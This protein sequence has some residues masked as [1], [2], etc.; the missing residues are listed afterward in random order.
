MC[1]SIKTQIPGFEGFGFLTALL[2]HENKRFEIGVKRL[3]ARLSPGVPPHPHHSVYRERGP[4]SL[5]F[6]ALE[7]PLC[8]PPFTPRV[9]LRARVG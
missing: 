3:W 2:L 8:V 7:P 1:S 9:V 4:A 5:G 6:L